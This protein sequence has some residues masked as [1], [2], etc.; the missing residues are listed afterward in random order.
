MMVTIY[1]LIDGA[2]TELRVPQSE[3]KNNRWEG[4]VVGST[5]TEVLKNAGAVIKETI[6]G[7]A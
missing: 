4:Y 5:P 3:V 1:A 7:T 2:I 6:I